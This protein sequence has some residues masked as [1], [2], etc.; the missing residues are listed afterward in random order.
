MFYMYPLTITN[1]HWNLLKF[2]LMFIISRLL[3]L[4]FI[5][6]HYLFISGKGYNQGSGKTSYNKNLQTLT[7]DVKRCDY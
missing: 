7:P 4:F 6:F 5:N 1:N 2:L 3:F